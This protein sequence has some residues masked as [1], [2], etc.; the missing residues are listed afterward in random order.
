MTPISSPAVFGG[1]AAQGVGKGERD[2]VHGARGRHAERHVT[3]AAEVLQRIEQARPY[4]LQRG[5]HERTS[6]AQSKVPA[7]T[8][9]ATRS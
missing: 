9:R 2:A 1:I 3:D 8:S 4:D 5:A 6:F 7:S